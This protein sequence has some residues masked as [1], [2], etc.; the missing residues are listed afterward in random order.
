MPRKARIKD[1]YGTFYIYQKIGTTRHIFECDSDRERF[2][3]ILKQSQKKFHFKLYDFSIQ[4][5]DEYY[6]VMDVNGGDLSKVMKG[7]NIAYAMYADIKTHLQTK[8]LEVIGNRFMTG[9][10]IETEKGENVISSDGLFI[11]IGNIPNSDFVKSHLLVNDRREI[12]GCEYYPHQ[13]L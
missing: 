3:T 2:L 8:I 9:L 1:D 5:R 7:I 4:S 10:R 13:I 11:E 6:L 12:K